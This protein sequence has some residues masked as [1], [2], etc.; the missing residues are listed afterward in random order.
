[1]SGI[2]GFIDPHHKLDSRGQLERM[3][4]ALKHRPW[5]T[6]DVHHE[7]GLNAAIG[8]TGIGVF[9]AAPQP[10]W[11]GD[12][13][14]A[15]FLVGELYQVAG[16]DL[17]PPWDA[18]ERIAGL[19]AAHG[20][21]FA[22]RVHGVYQCA[23]LDLARRRLVIANDRFGLYPLYFSRQDGRLV[24]APEVKAI[25]RTPGFRKTLDQAALAQ[26]MRFQ[27][28]MGERTFF[29]DVHRLAPAS[30]MVC[31]LDTA[32]CRI[33]TYWSYADIPALP[34]VT[35]DEAV[36]EAG[37]LLRRAV[38]RLSSGT[39]RPGVYLSGGLDSRAIAGLVDRRPLSTLTF[40]HPHSRDVVLAKRIA[41]AIGSRHHW[42]DLTDGCWVLDHADFHLE[43]T[44]G[45]HSWI[46]SHG[47]STLT[48]GRQEMDVYLSGWDGGTLFG[49]PDTIGPLHQGAVDDQAVIQ[50]FFH[51]FNQKYTWPGLT[52]AEALSLCAGAMG[53]Q[54]QGLAYDS[55]R[56][57]LVPM[58]GLR[59]DVRSAFIYLRH[60]ASRLTFNMMAFY[61]SHMEVR[62]PYLDRELIDFLHGIPSAL[63]ANKALL[64]GVLDRELPLLTTIPY[65]KD[66][67]LPTRQRWRRAG[68]AFTVA[69][70]R[71]WRAWRRQNS[72][73]PETLYADYE[74]YLRGPLRTWGEE[75]LLGP[76]TV[77]RGLFDPDAVRSLWARHQS[78]LE[79]NFIGRLA[80]LMTYE[81]MLRRL[82][83]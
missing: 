51:L 16:R 23:I 12:R 76:R 24:F 57:E 64:L 63:R 32:D 78:G 1:M 48:L 27:F 34:A 54:L 13:S 42:V 71:R 37:R 73:Q 80:P 2:I 50:H 49:D 43:L 25:L 17:E 47:M 46:H 5:M 66:G 52:E 44:E 70:G 74:G 53:R 35:F 19:Y 11:S 14:V 83:D 8:R 15:V 62:F 55:M 9:N 22:A 69:V 41:K 21:D 31:D 56:A 29:E 7:R 61:R 75:L 65:N 72:P 10:V 38:S 30:I 4:A 26:Y 18:P 60:E 59:P 79:V 68:H 58:L 40:G 67:L 45:F 39:H 77:K 82:Y 81:M 3:V 33:V 20:L 28:V 36:I 6:A